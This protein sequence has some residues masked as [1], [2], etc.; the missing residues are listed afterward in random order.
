MEDAKEKTPVA[1][2]PLFPPCPFFSLGNSNSFPVSAPTLPQ[3]NP[4]VVDS[5]RKSPGPKSSLDDFADR[6]LIKRT[7]ALI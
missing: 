1:S 2:H 3:F 7:V 6:W 5:Q 4:H